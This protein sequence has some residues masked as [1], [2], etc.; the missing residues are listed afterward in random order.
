M[1]VMDDLRPVSLTKY[2]DVEDADSSSDESLLHSLLQYPTRYQ[3]CR[4]L[5]LQTLRLSIY[6][7]ATAL[8]SDVIR[9]VGLELNCG[10]SA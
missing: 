5:N 8:L 6:V 9:G 2:L 4:I 1:A 10:D 3:G 7:T